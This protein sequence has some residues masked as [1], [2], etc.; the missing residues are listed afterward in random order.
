MA[1]AGFPEQARPSRPARWEHP[2]A[3]A[4]LAGSQAAGHQ[5]PA[6]LLAP[7]HPEGDSARRKA[8]ARGLRPAA[9]G[10]ASRQPGAAAFQAA[11]SAPH[12]E[13]ELEAEAEAEAEQPRAAKA[14]SAVMVPQRAAAEQ[15]EPP[16]AEARAPRAAEPADAREA[17]R[18][19]AAAV[20]DAA[21]EP[22]AALRAAAGV[23]GAVA[24][25]AGAAGEVAEARAAAPLPG[26]A[27]GEQDEAEPPRVAAELQAVP[28]GAV[29][30]P[31]A[32]HPAAAAGLA[33][34]HAAVAWADRPGRPRRRGRLDPAP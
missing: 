17:Q 6:G 33:V 2:A 29:Q 7:V 34:D 25:H 26:E 4:R 32:G 11:E 27:A 22:Q 23:R 31:A 19:G 16:D 24:P 14:A 10:A 13:A 1:P 21:E 3:G 12:L 5:R 30:R 9:N 8:A 18:P 15:A 20:S 28:G